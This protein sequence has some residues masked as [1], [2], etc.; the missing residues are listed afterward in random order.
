MN[1]KFMS[2][3]NAAIITV[4]IVLIGLTVCGSLWDY[5]M[6]KTLYW[7]QLP[8]ENLFG[9]VFAFIGILPTFVGWAFLGA[10]ILYLSRKQCQ[11]KKKRG[12]LTA[13]SVLLFVLAFFYFCNTLFLVNES[14]FSV[15]WAIAYSVGVAVLAG[16]AFLGYWLSKHS[17]NPELLKKVLFLTAVSLVTMVIIMSSKE[18]MDR[19]RFR[20]VMQMGKPEYFRNWWQSGSELQAS[21]SAN[22]VSDEFSSFPSG[23]SAYAMFAIFLFPAF[24]DYTAKC[25]KYRGLLFVGGC[26]WWGLTALSRLTVGAHYVTDVCIA[27][28]VTIA[29][30]AIVA[31]LFRR[32]Q[33]EKDKFV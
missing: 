12:W 27:G 9:V 3:K 24:A 13:L 22:V 15:H 28:L 8:S 33:K 16:A 10:S 17:D 20:W 5:Q 23:H 7:G 29:A 18:I 4:A 11:S 26:L 19:P 6:A 31:L 21:Q 30:Y 2:K 25:K 14:A 32:F 1:C